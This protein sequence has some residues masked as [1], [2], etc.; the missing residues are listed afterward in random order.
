MSDFQI[1]TVSGQA[2]GIKIQDVADKTENG[3]GIQVLA[4]GSGTGIYR[5]TFSVKGTDYSVSL[6]L[7]VTWDVI[8]D[9]SASTDEIICSDDELED[10]GFTSDSIE[11]GDSQNSD[12][13]DM[14]PDQ[15]SDSID[16]VPD[17]SNDSAD[18][19]SDETSGWES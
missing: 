11:G 4:N 9:Q 16:M 17:Q 18:G 2:D 7:T 12:S 3:Y 15:N 14:V 13:V 10:P 19:F 6:Q 1:E 5:I 8:A